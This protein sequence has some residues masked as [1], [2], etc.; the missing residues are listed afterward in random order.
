MRIADIVLIIG[1]IIILVLYFIFCRR[2]Y[3][4]DYIISGNE[5][6]A[7]KLMIVAHPDD[8]LIFGGRQL[9]NETGWKVI[10]ITNASVHSNNMFRRSSINIR[11]KEFASVMNQLGYPYEMWDFEDNFFNSNWDES[12]IIPKLLKEFNKNY[13]KIVTHNLQGEYGHR[14]HKRVSQI[15]HRLQPKN[16]YVFDINETEIN[17]HLKKLRNLL[18]L[19]STQHEIIE[20]HYKYVLHQTIRSISKPKL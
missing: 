3:S 11:E 7:D 2:L 9:L 19:Y 20:K 5:G 13:K 10:T 15:V 1:I 17:P 18:S 4:S 14:Q 12:I 8:E 16:L 6:F